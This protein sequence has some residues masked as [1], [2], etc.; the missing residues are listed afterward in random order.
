M[1]GS[2]F[3]GG[4]RDDS[5]LGMAFSSL[6]CGLVVSFLLVAA[7]VFA[8]ALWTKNFRDTLGKHTQAT[9]KAMAVRLANAVG[10][11]SAIP[12]EKVEELVMQMYDKEVGCVVAL[13]NFVGVELLQLNG[14]SMRTSRL[15]SVKPQVS[16]D[17]DSPKPR[18]LSRMSSNAYHDEFAE[19]SRQFRTSFTKAESTDD[20]LASSSHPN[21]VAVLLG[22]SEPYDKC[23][24]SGNLPCA[25]APQISSSPAILGVERTESDLLDI[26]EGG[27]APAGRSKPHATCLR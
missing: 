5:S 22:S 26:A 13:T 6:L 20:K 23:Y 17:S 15:P 3:I 25:S 16:V 1:I 18:R 8:F 27:R 24:K 4:V 7:G 9:T 10:V 2:W 21:D 14:G 11:F 19:R 12:A